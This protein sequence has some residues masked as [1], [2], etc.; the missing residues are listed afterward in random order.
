MYKKFEPGQIETNMIYKQS[1]DG[2]MDI[3]FG[4]VLVVAGINGVFTYM[5]WFIP[6]YLRFLIILLLIPMFLMKFLLT[7]PRIGYIKMKPV[8]GGRRNILKI[9]LLISATLTVIMLISSIFKIGLIH[10]Q[11]LHVSPVI[12]FG[13]LLLI[14]SFVAWLIGLYSLYFV[15]IAAGIGFFLDK[16]LGLETI[17]DLPSDLF[18]L[19]TPGLIISIYGIFRLVKFLKDHP[20]RN[21][22]A[23]FNHE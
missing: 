20:I 9:F 14:M 4:L 17:F 1:R 2:V 12:L 7:S 3:Y 21:L 11:T 8:K 16:P 15:G 6:W 13:G 5:D 22:K 10:G 23:D 19:I 18:I